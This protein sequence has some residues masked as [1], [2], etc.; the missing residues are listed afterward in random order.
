[1]QSPRSVSPL[2]AMIVD[3]G[4]SL[5]WYLEFLRCDMAFRCNDYRCNDVR[6]DCFRCVDVI[7]IFHTP[8]YKQ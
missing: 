7:R 8:P 1:M 3:K 2:C 5:Y 6:C 4:T